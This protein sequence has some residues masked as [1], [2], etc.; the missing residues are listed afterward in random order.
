MNHKTAGTQYE[1]LAQ[2]RLENTRRTHCS[3]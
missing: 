3:H 1:H 2:Q